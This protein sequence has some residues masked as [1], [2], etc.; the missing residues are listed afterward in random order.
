[1]EELLH[2]VKPKLFIG[3]SKG[4]EN[5]DVLKKIARDHIYD[6]SKGCENMWTVLRFLI[7]L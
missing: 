3:S 5:F 1:M 7:Q 2:H 4:L 6:E